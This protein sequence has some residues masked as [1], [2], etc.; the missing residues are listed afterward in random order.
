MMSFDPSTPRYFLNPH[1]AA[2]LGQVPP[3]NAD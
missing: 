2:A 1:F 3:R